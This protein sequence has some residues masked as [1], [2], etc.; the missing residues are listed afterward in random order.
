MS[1]P[2]KRKLTA[3]QVRTRYG[4]ISNM[5]LWRWL[6]D[7][8]LAFPQP[9]AIHNRRYWDEEELDSFDEERKRAAKREVA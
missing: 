6:H 2:R 8:K 4:N 1:N 9:M 7:P 5:T 3:P